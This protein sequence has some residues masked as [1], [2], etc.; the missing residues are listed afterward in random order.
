MGDFVLNLMDGFGQGSIEA[1][2]GRDLVGR[3]EGL[4][5]NRLAG[6]GTEDLPRRFQDEQRQMGLPAAHVRFQSKH[7]GY[8]SDQREEVWNLSPG[9]RPIVLMQGSDPSGQNDIG[10]LVESG[11]S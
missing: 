11:Y 8:H 6:V 2:T 9:L 10:I 5:E 3:I 4:F 7:L 1:G